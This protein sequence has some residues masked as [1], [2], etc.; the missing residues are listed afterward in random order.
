MLITSVAFTL[1]IKPN[2]ERMYMMYW[3]PL[4]PEKEMLP[5]VPP[6]LPFSLQHLFAQACGLRRAELLDLRVRNIH[7][8]ESGHLWIR[9]LKGRRID[10]EVPIIPMD[11]R[12]CL[13]LCSTHAAV[14]GSA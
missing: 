4:Y 13:G 5:G 7:R 8:D 3:L 10:R 9:V 1:E 2:T 6:P 14:C 12:F 11:E